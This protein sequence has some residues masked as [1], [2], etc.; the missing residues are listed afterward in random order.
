MRI[1]SGFAK[2]KPATPRPSGS[3]ARG[4]LKVQGLATL[5][6]ATSPMG[7][8]ICHALV[9]RGN[10]MIKM[11]SENFENECLFSRQVL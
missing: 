10:K 9:A 1:E 4:I 11:K 5:F 7:A 8:P 2:G 6:T 3:A